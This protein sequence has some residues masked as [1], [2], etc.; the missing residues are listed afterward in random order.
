MSTFNSGKLYPPNSSV[1]IKRIRLPRAPTN[2]YKNFTEGD[3]WLD[4][5]TSIWYKYL[6]F[7]PVLLGVWG[8]L[9]N[10][11]AELDTL[12]GDVGTPVIASG[13]NIN[14]RG[15]T[16]PLQGAIRFS[17]GGLGNL[18]AQVLVD[19]TTIVINTSNQLSD[20]SGPTNV[21]TLQTTDGASHIIVSI[22]VAENSSISL[23]GFLIAAQSDYSNAVE[24]DIQVGAYRAALGNVTMIGVPLINVQ[25]TSVATFASVVN[26][27]TQTLDITV[28]GVNPDTYD[29]KIEY[30]YITQ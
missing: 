6:R 27:G 8:E 12:T 7:D 21:A 19:G 11:G 26:I 29:W 13:H 22:P 30:R 23:S 15:D 5:V 20:P 18:D 24:G 28:T 17:N 3:E 16:L 9:A 4:T 14:I 10:S 25:S 1:P 2:E